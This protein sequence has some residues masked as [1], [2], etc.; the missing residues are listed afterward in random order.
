M[1][2]AVMAMM[3][4]MAIIVTMAPVIGITVPITEMPPITQVAIVIANMA[5]PV[6]RVIRAT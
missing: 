1:V 3:A 6:I 5:T 2:K 4:M